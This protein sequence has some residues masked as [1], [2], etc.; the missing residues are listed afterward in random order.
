M[1]LLKLFEA[2]FGFA[3]TRDLAIE[4]WKHLFFRRNAESIDVMIGLVR[5]NAVG[6]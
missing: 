1:R 4:V 6:N 5:R 2:F 3:E